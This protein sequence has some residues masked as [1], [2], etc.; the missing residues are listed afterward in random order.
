MKTCDKWPHA[1]EK[2]KC[3]KQR[4]NKYEARVSNLILFSIAVNLVDEYRF[5]GT[6]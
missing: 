6:A 5:T 2:A 3:S 4:T 1:Q